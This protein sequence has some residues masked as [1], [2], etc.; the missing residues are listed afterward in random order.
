MT[1]FSH[2]TLAAFSEV[3]DELAN[4]SDPDAEI[5]K[6]RLNLPLF[7]KHHE[8]YYDRY[9]DSFDSKALATEALL[10]DLNQEHEGGDKIKTLIEDALSVYYHFNK[11][12]WLLRNVECLNSVLRF[13]GY[14]LQ[15]K[16][17]RRHRLVPVADLLIA[18]ELKRKTEQLGL[19]P[20]GN[21]LRRALEHVESDPEDTL[22]AA[23]SMAMSVCT[24]LLERMGKSLPATRD[25]SHLSNELA[26]HLRLSPE[27]EDIEPDIKRI[28]G[29]LA[30][31]AYG[32]GALRTRGGDAEGRGE[33]V[34]RVD[35]RIARLA[36]NAAASYSLFILETWEKRAPNA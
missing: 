27:R 23:C 12:D 2:Q 31:V 17:R 26:R 13:D 21:E 16:D 36:V 32:I 14:E 33:G 10:V 22:T 34:R 25:I 7:F 29:A 1:M 19:E 8:L 3:L 5:Y 11:D 35:A 4:F 28:L 15:L 18:A 24:A 9:R 20:V 30:N 6:A